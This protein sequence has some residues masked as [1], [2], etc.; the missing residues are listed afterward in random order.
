MLEQK[1]LRIYA[2]KRV[3][4]IVSLYS[5]HPSTKAAQI[6]TKGDS[7]TLKFLIKESESVVSGFPHR[8]NKEVNSLRRHTNVNIYTPNMEH[9]NI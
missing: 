3:T 1:S 8:F 5:P 9:L 2:L 7:L 4:I 6:S